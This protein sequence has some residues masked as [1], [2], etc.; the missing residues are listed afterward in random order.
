MVATQTATLESG[1][2]FA[3]TSSWK[4]RILAVVLLLGIAGYFWAGSRYPA[5]YKKYSQGTTV[6]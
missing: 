2:L 3:S 4:S 5:L 6:K 1:I